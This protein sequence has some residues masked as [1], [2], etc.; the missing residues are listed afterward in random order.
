MCHR[1]LMQRNHRLDPRLR[2]PEEVKEELLDVDDDEAQPIPEQHTHA[3]GS[4]SQEQRVADAPMA[5]DSAPDAVRVASSTH[6]KP[7]AFIMIGHDVRANASVLL[8][9]VPS[10][11][12]PPAK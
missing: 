6:I 1:T 11:K 10:V 3:L 4:V 8:S 12:S 7:L 9:A 2:T 5:D